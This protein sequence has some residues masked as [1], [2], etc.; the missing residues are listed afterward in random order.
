MKLF[1]D[2]KEG[3]AKNYCETYLKEARVIGH[4]IKKLKVGVKN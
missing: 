2:S 1:Y 4:Y 3:V